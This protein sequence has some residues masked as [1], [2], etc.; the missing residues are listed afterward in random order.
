M[1]CRPVLPAEDFC[2]YGNDR[3][4]TRQSR[5]YAS[6]GYGVFGS[7]IPFAAGWWGSGWVHVKLC[8]GLM[9]LAYQLYCGV[10]LRRFQNYSNTFSHR[11]YRVFNEIPVLLMIGALYLVVF[12]PF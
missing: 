6:V 11:W 10:L 3:C 9:L 2:Q 5:I 12:K 1:V 7:A 8:L 4:A